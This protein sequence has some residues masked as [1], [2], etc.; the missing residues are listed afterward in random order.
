MD[1]T[2]LQDFFDGLFTSLV[3][4]DTIVQIIALAVLLLLARFLHPRLSS[5]LVN[6]E[7]WLAKISFPAGLHWI[8]SLV[9]HLQ[10]ILLPALTALLAQIFVSLLGAFGQQN[11][12][13]Q[14]AAS[15]IMVW[16]FYKLLMAVVEWRMEPEQAASW[17]K[18][19]LKPL[20]YI[21]VLL[22]LVGLLD[23]VLNAG[24]TL[25]DGRITFGAV[26][27]GLLSLFVFVVIARSSRNLLDETVLPRAGL[28]KSLTQVLATFVGYIIVIVG[29]IISLNIIGLPLTALTVVAGGLSVGI[30]FGMQE[31]I[32]NFISGFILLFE[33]SIGLGD[34]VKVDEMVGRVEKIGIRSM[35]ISGRDNVDII[36]PNG[37]FLSQ[38]V[39]NFTGVDKKVRMNVSVGVGYESRP[40]EV[41]K[42][43]LESVDHPRILKDPP[44]KVQFVDFGDSSL[45]FDLMVWTNDVFQIPDTASELRFA[46]WDV[47]EKYGISIP[48]PQRDLHI[49]SLPAALIAHQNG[50]SAKRDSVLE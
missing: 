38:T 23:D 35:R 47:F 14:W 10:I 4:V 50:E 27:V 33:R 39:T 46:I 37:R 13:L 19:F 43:L 3:T 18:K 26:M 11:N 28:E 48:F 42:A 6:A 5:R 34:V 12:L 8:A 15:L 29:V 30:G 32:N 16:F 22:S 7:K 41:E 40:R 36:V 44:P 2:L 21:C 20:A 49:R 31:L 1:V 9:P 17:Q 45:N 24:V 25:D